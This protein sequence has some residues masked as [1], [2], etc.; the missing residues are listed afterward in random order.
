MA[1]PK[2]AVEPKQL[3]LKMPPEEHQ[4][5]LE[6]AF[7]AT[8]EAE[9]PSDVNLSNWIRESLRVLMDMYEGGFENGRDVVHQNFVDASR[10]EM[11]AKLAALENQ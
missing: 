4:R 1:R 11:R 10:A 5:L 2:N 6:V 7:H 9:Y 8:P 3:S